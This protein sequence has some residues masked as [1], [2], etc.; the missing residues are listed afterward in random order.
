MSW[1]LF[2][3]VALLVGWSLRAAPAITARTLPTGVKLDDGHQ[4][5]IVFASFPALRIYEKSVQAGAL[6]GGDPIMTSTML[7]EC[8]ETKAPQRLKGVDDIVV[9]A[10]YDPG[11]AQTLWEIINVPDN[12]SVLWPDGSGMAQWGYL[13]RAEFSP[14]AKGEQPEVTLTIVVT[15][16]DPYECVEACP[17]FLDGTGSCLWTPNCGPTT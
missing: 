6:E 11:V 15:N 8:C 7:N 2:G 10:A 3:S 16:W 12:I 13:R 14:L 4:S 9:V 17:V 1:L 5:L